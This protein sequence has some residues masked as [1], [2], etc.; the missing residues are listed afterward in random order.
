MARKK[1][2]STFLLTEPNWKS[3]SLLTD[4]TEIKK[5]IADAEYFVH[6]EIASKQKQD[7]LIK[8]IKQ[9][10][11]WDKDEIKYITS[12]D[13]G[14][15]SAMG[16]T[17][18]V[19]KK[20]GFWPQHCINYLNEISKP[21]WLKLGIKTYQEKQEDVD[22]QNDTKVIS[23]QERM[24]EQVSSLCGA[25]E[26]NLDTFVDTGEFNLD[27]F[28][29]YNDMRAH[30][31][32][33][34]PAH[35][36]IIRDSYDS[37]IAEA[38]EIV[39]W[40]DDDIKEAYGH[41][42]SPKMRKGYLAFFEKIHTSCD[43][44][45]A[46]GKATRKPRK[47][48]PIDRD[49]LVKKLKYQINDSDLGIASVNPID[50]IDASELWVYNTKL[51]KLGVY[52]KDEL[53][54]GLYIKGTSILNFNPVSSFQKTLRKP[55]EQIKAIKN[56]TKARFNTYFKEITTTPTKLTGRVSDTIILLKVF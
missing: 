17:A 9:E 30:S 23:I 38:K 4:P 12:I 31:T 26:E 39:E 8:W 36:K 37:D 27:N 14:Y 32:P 42:T 15:F 35:A 7:A 41:F 40:K 16:K 22:K 56:S 43:T 6:Y 45:I 53:S 49:K 13:K 21:Q 51:R 2:R 50:I 20:V 3:I 28:D 47:A 46:T 24:R 10:S 33:V 1:Q 29:P 18:W 5:A 34:K 48:K 11:G 44:I 55:A 25:W 52:R 54:T 19:S